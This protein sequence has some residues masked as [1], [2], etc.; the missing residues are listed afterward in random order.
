MRQRCGGPDWGKT[1]ART[2]VEAEHAQAL[3]VGALH[4][5]GEGQDS[6]CVGHRVQDEAPSGRVRHELGHD[7]SVRRVPQKHVSPE[8]RRD[9][10]GQ[11]VC[12]GASARKGEGV[13]VCVCV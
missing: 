6:D 8:P 5:L 1:L 12:A 4:A 13:C 11:T 10:R 7:R 9:L 2:L 3:L